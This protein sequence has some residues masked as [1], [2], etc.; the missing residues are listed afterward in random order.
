MVANQAKNSI[1]FADQSKNVAT[2]YSQERT[3][4]YLL[5]DDVYSFLIDEGNNLI[6]SSYGSGSTNQAKS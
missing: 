4:F 6:I 3:N 5:I 2:S 1:T